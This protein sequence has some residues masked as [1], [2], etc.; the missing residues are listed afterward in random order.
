MDELFRGNRRLFEGLYIYDKWDW[1]RQ[2]PVIRID[3]TR[4]THS[5]PE[6]MKVSLCSY[7]QTVAKRYDVPLTTESAPDRFEELI[8]LLREK[9]GE[10][11]VVLIDEYDKPVTSHLFD[12]LLD[13]IRK[14]VHDFYQVMKGADDY[15]RLVFLTGV[16]KFSGLSVFSALNNPHDITISDDYAAI[17]GYTQK[18]LEDNFPEYIDR[19]AGRYGMTKDELLDKIRYWYDG[20]TWDGQTSVYNP[21]STLLFFFEQKFVGY[22]FNTG[23][24]TFLIDILQRRERTDIVLEPITVDESLLNGGYDPQTLSEIPLLFQ[25]GYL[26]VKEGIYTSDGVQY[27]LGVPNMEVNKALLTNLL[28]AYGKYPAQNV[29]ILRKEMEQ[30]LRECDE[31]GFANCLEAM[32]ATVPYELQSG[33]EHYY[34]TIMLIW[35][36]L[37]GFRIQG[38]KPNNRG[39]ADAVWEQ[40][41]LTVV[42]EL[43]YHAEKKIET[44]LDEAMAQ[45]HDRR[46]YNPY[47][48]KVILLGIAFSGKDIG[49]RMEVMNR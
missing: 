5:T 43:K 29:D 3:W 20:Y 47:L 39:R 10:K 19:A 24:P 38:E 33:C 31:S 17:C 32:M 18:E 6:E 7:L 28:L 42:A 16:S 44:L 26:T 8:R 45:I 2:Y 37:L 4:I 36:R 14:A 27:T 15:L 40:P 48:G 22:W 25:T 41:G 46:Y 23:T 1:S 12:P 11:V 9:T 35:M 30:R 49:C 21:F 13:S 34:H